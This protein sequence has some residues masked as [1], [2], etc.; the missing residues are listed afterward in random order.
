M[1]V[2]SIPKKLCGT[3]VFASTLSATSAEVTEPMPFGLYNAGIVLAVA[4]P[5]GVLLFIVP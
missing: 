3:Y 1:P 2:I 4:P 5:T